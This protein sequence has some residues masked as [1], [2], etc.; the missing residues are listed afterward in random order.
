M[1]RRQSFINKIRELD[2]TFKSERKRVYLWRKGLHFIPVP[3]SDL[4]D[5]AF[6]ANA[7]RQAGVGNEEI[8]IFLGLA[9]N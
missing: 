6:V 1:V 8:Q 5:D 2:Y 4:L 9:K 7:L 3:K